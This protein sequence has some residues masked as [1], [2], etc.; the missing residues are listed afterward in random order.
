MEITMGKKNMNAHESSTFPGKKRGQ[1]LV[2]F[3]IAL[4]VLLLL[5]FGIIEFGRLVFSW[6]AVQNS[7]RFA[8]RYAVTGDYD[9]SYCDDAAAALEAE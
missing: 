1:G 5:I 9:E 3:A 2:E 8:L 7:A 4:P 6:L